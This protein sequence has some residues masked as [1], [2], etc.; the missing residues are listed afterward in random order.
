MTRR[1]IDQALCD[2]VRR[3]AGYHE[4]QDVAAILRLH[5]A[6]ISRIKKRGWHAT[7]AGVAAIGDQLVPLPLP[8]P[9]LATGMI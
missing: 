3:L 4:L 7:A 6:Q 5:P 1:T 8:G 9:Q 2:R